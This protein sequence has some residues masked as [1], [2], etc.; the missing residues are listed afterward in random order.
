MIA[1]F[2]EKMPDASQP[3]I[4]DVA[5]IYRCMTKGVRGASQEFEYGL[6]WITSRRAFLKVY[7]DRLE[8]GDW[9]IP[10]RAIEEAE[11]FQT[12]SGIIPCFILK[13][14]TADHAFQ[15]GLNGNK[16]WKGDLPFQ[17]KRTK[18][19]IKYSA[20]SIGLR[21]ALVAGVVWHVF[22]RDR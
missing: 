19:R 2:S 17:V 20:F 14:R 7:P 3:A 15:F 22:F 8:C 13:V 5:P 21:I 6:K 12:R 11:L 4:D 10:Y 1:T 9:N 16:F 18:G